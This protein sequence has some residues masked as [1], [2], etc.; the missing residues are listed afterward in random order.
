MVWKSKAA[1]SSRKRKSRKAKKSG[2]CAVYYSSVS[3]TNIHTVVQHFL[4]L[5]RKFL[6]LLVLAEHME[7]CS[8]CVT[9]LYEMEGKS[10]DVLV[11]KA[12]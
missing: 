6:C 10:F 5:K 7:T 1:M 3:V 8:H 2:I 12:P 9:H 4:L 11:V